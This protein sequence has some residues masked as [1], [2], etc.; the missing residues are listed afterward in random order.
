MR[1]TVEE[2]KVLTAVGYPCSKA[3]PVFDRFILQVIKNWIVGRSG[4]R[5]ALE[6]FDPATDDIHMMVDM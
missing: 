3:F 2:N 4:M 5:L 6:N 1:N